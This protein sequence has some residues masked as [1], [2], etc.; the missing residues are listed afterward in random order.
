MPGAESGTKIILTRTPCESRHCPS[1]TMT[2]YGDGKVVYESG[3]H[4]NRTHHEKRIAASQVHVLIEK[5]KEIDL[6]A[7]S[8][9]IDALDCETEFSDISVS[10]IEFFEDGR[11]SSVMHGN[12]CYS[13]SAFV[14]LDQLGKL[15]DDTVQVSEWT[16]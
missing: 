3:T 8:K 5:I 10:E 9:K 16:Q 11:H 12:R 14:P 4:P 7:L 2:I 6:S 15:I 1:Y 13:S